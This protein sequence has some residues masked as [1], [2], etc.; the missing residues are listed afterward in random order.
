MDTYSKKI[1]KNS[2]HFISCN[3]IAVFVGIVG[4]KCKSAESESVIMF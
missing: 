2:N 4:I 3:I 1:A